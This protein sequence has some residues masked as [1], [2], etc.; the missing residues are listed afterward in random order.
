MSNSLETTDQKLLC[1]IYKYVQIVT[2]GKGSCKQITKEG[3]R[4]SDYILDEN[5]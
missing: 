4:D 2:T 5:I 3:T 1:L